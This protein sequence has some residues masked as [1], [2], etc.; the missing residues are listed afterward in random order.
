MRTAGAATRTLRIFETSLSRF[1]QEVSNSTS[2]KSSRSFSTRNI[3]FTS[4][5]SISRPAW[6]PSILTKPSC[7]ARFPE[8]T[9]T[10]IFLTLCDVSQDF[11]VSAVTEFTLTLL[12]SLNVACAASP[13]CKPWRALVFI[14]KSSEFM[15]LSRGAVAQIANSAGWT[16]EETLQFHR[17]AEKSEKASLHSVMSGKDWG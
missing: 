4:P 13:G 6:L 2:G 1:P 14:G 3:S 15:E 12:L 11:E 16:P 5:P 8:S 10:R 7:H 9:R 17:R